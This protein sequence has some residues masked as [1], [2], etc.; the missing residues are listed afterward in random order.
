[1][2]N[3]YTTRRHLFAL[4]LI[5]LLGVFMNL[6]GHSSDPLIT[7][8]LGDIEGQRERLDSF[9]ANSGAFNISSDRTVSIKP[10][11]R[12]VFMGDAVDKG[13]DSLYI[14]ETLT[15]LLETQRDQM[16]AI[17]GNRD[18]NK[19]RLPHELSE[20]GL[21]RAPKEN[22]ASQKFDDWMKDHSLSK[23]LYTDGVTRLKWM[24][25]R[26]MGAPQAFE[27]RRQDLAKK[28]TTAVSDQD[29]FESF[30]SD[31]APLAPVV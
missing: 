16:V 17:L 24:L 7:V 26:T 22:A 30:L 21:S 19:L 12:V 10:G 3:F 8:V 31:L 23:A 11:Y 14:L 15:H 25:E 5:F 2:A 20:E 18:I 27:F 1:M 9:I 6:T 4:T 13:P 28:A 29:V